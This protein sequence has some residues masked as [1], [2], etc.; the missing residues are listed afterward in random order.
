VP[1]NGGCWQISP[2]SAVF[3]P[4]T[5]K[6]MPELKKTP[7]YL[8]GLV[9]ARARAGGDVERYAKIAK[10]VA[11]EL[12]KARSTLAACDLLIRKI[13]TRL[14]PEDI[15]PIRIPKNYGGCRG[16]LINTV[17]QI[18]RSVAPNSVTTGEI[19]IEIQVRFQF[20][21]ETW[22]ARAE[23]KNNSIGRLLRKLCE[24]GLIE[25]LHNP[26]SLTEEGGRWRWKSDATQSSDQLRE[27]IEAQG[28]SVIQYDVVED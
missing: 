6:R 10:D 27:Q 11:R 21:F 24:E 20:T 17:E 12:K 23:W 18:L 13:D 22:Q 9:E 14:T 19:S 8:K 5:L 15:E 16:K 28:G 25:R 1:L 7:S 2:K 26:K 4:G 3:T